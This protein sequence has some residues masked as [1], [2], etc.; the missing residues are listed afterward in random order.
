VGRFFTVTLLLLVGCKDAFDVVPPNV[1]ILS[2]LDCTKASGQVPV[3]VVASD[4]HLKQTSV[5]LDSGLVGQGTSETLSFTCTVPD[6]FCHTLRAKATDYR[7][8]FGLASVVVNP[9]SEVEVRSTPT[10]A[11]VWLDGEDTHDTTDCVLEKIATGRHCVRL[12]KSGYLDWQDTVSVLRGETAAVSATLVAAPYPDSVIAEIPVGKEPSALAWNEA[13]GRVYCA[14]YW[15]STVSVIDPS[16]LKVVRTVATGSLPYALTWNSANNRFY[17]ACVGGFSPQICVYDGS[18]NSRIATIPVWIEYPAMASNST[19]NR[20]YCVDDITGAVVIDGVSNEVTDTLAGSGFTATCWNQALDCVYITSSDGSWSLHAFSGS[21]DT[22]VGI[23]P[24]VYA[25]SLAWCA[26]GDK[27]YC[28]DDNVV[29]VI[30]CATNQVVAR[31]AGLNGVNLTAWDETSNKLYCA[32]RSQEGVTVIDCA[33]ESVVKRI[34]T[35]GHHSQALV[36]DK[37]N[38]RVFSADGDNNCVLVIGTK[39]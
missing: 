11:S 26:A 6:T 4:A 8:N 13:R 25:S 5:Y 28:A 10:G 20:V 19:D 32:S 34:P 16:T 38:D 36:Y 30:D 22:L 33:T 27:L 23:V 18:S 7:G 24:D 37:T 39:P 29:K 35:P 14:N 17:C 9:V 12:T 31:I 21:T 3:V 1:R 15:D 2:P